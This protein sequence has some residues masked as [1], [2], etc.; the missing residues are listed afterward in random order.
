MRTLLTASALALALTGCASLSPDYDRPAAPIPSALPAAG[1]E[2]GIAVAGADWRIVF[3]DPALQ[4][5]IETALENNRDLRV[6][7][8]NVQAAKARYGITGAQRLPSLSASASVTEREVF[9]ESDSASADPSLAFQQADS[10]SAQL[11]STAY[12]LDLFGRVNALNEQAL[13]Q[14]FAA[15]ENRR[16]AELSLVGAV[17]NAWLTL[18]ASER[19]LALAEETVG[20][21]E[22]SLGLTQKL[23]DA[24]LSNELDYQRARGSVETAKADKARFEAQVSQ[25]RNA[26]QLLTGT[27]VPSTLADDADLS[28]SPVELKLAVT[29]SSDVLLSRPDVMSAERTL[30]AANANIGAARAAFFPRITLTGSAGY[31]SSELDGLFTDGT[32]IWSFTPSVSVPIFTGGANRANLK[33]AEAQRDI[34]LAQYELAI[35]AAFRE[36]ADALAVAETIDER[37]ASLESFV[38]ASRRALELS[39]LRLR[40][41]VDSYLSVLDAQRSVYQAEQALIAARQERASNAVALYQAL[42]G[43][44][45]T[46]Q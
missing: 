14:Y 25:A 18:A 30:Q 21:Q 34:A 42:G 15:E 5:V 7:T 27:P 16:N 24:G 31:S 43:A 8:L 46:A 45:V 41:G 40:E 19:L 1:A 28:P 29:Q 17:A 33:L 36:T 3:T 12:E 4:S 11:A 10:A 2:D 39:D 13:Q 26:L 23:L 38:A 32:G 22:E 20:T 44:S 9:D 37:I 35:Q 6:A